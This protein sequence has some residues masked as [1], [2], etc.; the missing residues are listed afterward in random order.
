MEMKQQCLKEEIENKNKLIERR[1]EEAVHHQAIDHLHLRA[2]YH[3]QEAIDLLHL[4]AGHHQ[5]VIDH[6]HQRTGIQRWIMNKD[7]KEKKFYNNDEKI[8]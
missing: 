6:L 7:K 4:K 2:G 8:E 5:Q 3:H 1:K